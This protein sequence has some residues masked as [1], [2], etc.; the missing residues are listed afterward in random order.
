MEHDRHN[1][2]DVS[3]L[4]VS[5]FMPAIRV[6][7]WPKMYKSLL[8]SCKKYSFELVLVSPFDLPE[9]LKQYQNIKIFKDLG[10]PSRCAQLASIKCDGKLLYHC[11]DDA[12]F[13]EDSIDNAI[14]FYYANCSKKDVINMRYREGAN[15]SGQSMPMEYWIAWTHGDLKLAGIPN[16]FKISL[17]HLIDAEYFRDLGGYDCSFEYQNF[18][19]HDL[20][21][22]IQA[23]GGRIFDSPTDVTTCDHSQSDHKAIHN[24]HHEHDFPLF[25]QLYSDPN[26]LNSRIKIDINNWSQQQPIWTRRFKT[27]PKNYDEIANG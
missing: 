23:N 18:N 17:H 26:I 4:D 10:S 1:Q 13:L 3:A 7:N 11:V 6:P 22:R 19:L 20:M 8:T 12:I 25:Y 2:T 5:V 27:I 14:D 16:H 9:E 24:A 15:Y 21:F